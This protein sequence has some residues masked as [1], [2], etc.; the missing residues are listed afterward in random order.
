VLIHTRHAGVD[1]A[2]LAVHP[3]V[4]DTTYRRA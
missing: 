1:H 3:T 4:L 2:G